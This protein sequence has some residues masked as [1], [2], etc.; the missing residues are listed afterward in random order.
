MA[1]S[2][3]A[4]TCYMRHTHVGRGEISCL[5]GG[6]HEET[7]HIQVTTRERKIKSRRLQ[8]IEEQS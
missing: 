4:G 1:T 8:V 5:E 2:R 6:T 7:L 3:M